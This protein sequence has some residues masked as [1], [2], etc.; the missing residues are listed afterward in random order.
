MLETA[1]GG[2]GWV[3]FFWILGLL[4]TELKTGLTQM[5][6]RCKTTFD[7][8]AIEQVVEADAVWI[9]VR[10]CKGLV[11]FQGF[12]SRRRNWLLRAVVPYSGARLFPK[13]HGLSGSVS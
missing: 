1:A 4:P 11:A 6:S 9:P 3:R 2:W 13:E 10:M 12:L 7:I 8:Q 5:C